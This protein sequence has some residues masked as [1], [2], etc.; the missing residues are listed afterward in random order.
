[1]SEKEEKKVSRKP[2]AECILVIASL[3]IIALC[4]VS[5]MSA[6]SRSDAEKA[7]RYEYAGDILE[8]AC[9]L[10]EITVPA[11][12]AAVGIS[13]KKKREKTQKELEELFTAENDTLENRNETKQK[14]K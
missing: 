11:G 12:A 14:E 6:S 5:G 3:L 7:E 9:D 1:M 4:I 10:L 8:I 2:L 13:A